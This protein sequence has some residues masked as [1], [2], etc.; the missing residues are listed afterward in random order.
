VSNPRSVKMKSSPEIDS[1]R[2]QRRRHHSYWGTAPCSRGLPVTLEAKQYARIA[3]SCPRCFCSHHPAPGQN[4][5]AYCTISTQ[6]ASDTQHAT[7]KACVHEPCAPALIWSGA[8]NWNLCPSAHNAPVRTREV[9]SP[10]SR[11]IFPNASLPARF[12]LMIFASTSLPASMCI[13]NPYPCAPAP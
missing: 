12:A 4:V 11:P 5:C 3:I 13:G 9:V 6:T 1:R 2:T 8:I 7:D 10:S